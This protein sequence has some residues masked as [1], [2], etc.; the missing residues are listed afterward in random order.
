MIT[1]KF[2]EIGFLKILRNLLKKRMFNG[3]C[4]ISSWIVR[5]YHLLHMHLKIRSYNSLSASFCFYPYPRTLVCLA[6]VAMTP[7]HDSLKIFNLLGIPMIIIEESSYYIWN[8]VNKWIA[9]TTFFC[10][11]QKLP[12]TTNVTM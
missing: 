6:S 5:F 3:S 10:R 7:F 1:W 9:V 11:R 12:F 2:T 8:L 4:S